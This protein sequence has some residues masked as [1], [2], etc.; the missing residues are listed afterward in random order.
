MARARDLDPCDG[1]Q[2]ALWPRYRR[3]ATGIAGILL[4]WVLVSEG[5]GRLGLDRRTGPLPQPVPHG[6]ERRHRAPQHG[7][8]TAP[9][10]GGHGT[11]AR[12]AAARPDRDTLDRAELDARLVLRAAGLDLLGVRVSRMPDRVRVEGGRS[13][14]ASHRRAVSQ[15]AALP[16]VEVRVEV[17]VAPP[18]TQPS[19][20]AAP[21]SR[22]TQANGSTSRDALMHWRTRTF[23]ASPEHTTFVPQLTARVTSVR[24]HAHAL[25]GLALR[26][27]ESEAAA[28]SAPAH[29]RLSRLID[30]HFLALRAD[31]DELNLRLAVLFGSQTR[32]RLLRR[33]PPD[34]QRRTPIVSAHA[35]RLEDAVEAMLT[36]DDLPADFHGDASPEVRPV[37]AVSAAFDTLWETVNS[38]VIQGSRVPGR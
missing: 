38:P 34:W 1:P 37:H 36:L 22:S 17:H 23:R 4:G 7:T 19:P 15:L 26:Y 9:P 2:A 28:L 35:A 8:T 20:P 11:A 29:A 25:Q 10:D 33:A 31:L 27:S 30:L 21:D 6:A 5:I 24:Q 12:P 14:A 32:P 18:L 3:L 16:H 13:E